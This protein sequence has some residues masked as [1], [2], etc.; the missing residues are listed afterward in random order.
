MTP[1]VTIGITTFK[2]NHLLK[3]AVYSVLN[4]SFSDFELLIGNDNPKQKLNFKTLNIPI[5]KMNYTNN[6]AVGIS[7]LDN[8]LKLEEIKPIENNNLT[9]LNYLCLTKSQ[10]KDMDTNTNSE[11]NKNSTSTYTKSA[12]QLKS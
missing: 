12:P 10:Q 2:R 3:E 4:Q 9:I 11:Q 5:D 7:L 6:V 1:F 8:Q